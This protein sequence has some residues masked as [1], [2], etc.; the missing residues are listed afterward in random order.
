MNQLSR[1]RFPCLGQRA[2][3]PLKPP[4]MRSPCRN[5]LIPQSR[6][7]QMPFFQSCS[8]RQPALR[9]TRCWWSFRNMTVPCRPR[10]WW[11]FTKMILPR[12]SRYARLS[13]RCRAMP[14]LQIPLP[15]LMLSHPLGCILTERSRLRGNRGIL[16]NGLGDYEKGAGANFKSAREGGGAEAMIFCRMDCQKGCCH[17]PN[18]HVGGICACHRTTDLVF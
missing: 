4:R 2:S 9:R 3:C 18:F 1:L 13:R 15:R 6:Q 8:C 10:L 11:S 5:T 17:I 12:R 7:R 14:W 16:R